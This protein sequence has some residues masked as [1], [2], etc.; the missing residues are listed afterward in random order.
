MLLVRL[1]PPVPE[2]GC[3]GLP[4]GGLEWGESPEEALIREVREETGLHATATGIADVYST[5]FDRTSDRPFD[6]LHFISIVY[7]IR[8]TGDELLHE[9]DGTTD[10][11][12]WLPLSEAR[13]AR[14]GALAAHGVGLVPDA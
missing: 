2:A 9:V 11:A 13:T 3:W 6:P 10:L 7:W 4:G 12:A 14:L 8:V 1:A 5:T